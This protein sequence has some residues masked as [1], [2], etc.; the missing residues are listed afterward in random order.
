MRILNETEMNVAAGG[1]IPQPF[2]WTEPDISPPG[3]D[4]FWLRH[5]LIEPEICADSNDASSG[6][7]GC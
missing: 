2:P 5:L 6:S 7:D 1:S 3:L 4:A